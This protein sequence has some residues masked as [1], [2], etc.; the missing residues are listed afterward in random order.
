[1]G[2]W[3][4]KPS[5]K[6]SA[7]TSTP[8]AILIERDTIILVNV[9]VGRGA[10][11]ITIAKHYRGVD[12]HDKYYNKWFM[13]KVPN[14]EWKKD[15]KFKLKAHMQEVNAIQE[16]EDVRL[17]DTFYKMRDVRR[18]VTEGEIMNVIGKLQTV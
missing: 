17:H 16:Y 15:S 2:R 10:S 7:P 3:L 18:I 5:G 8:T 14:K 1:M 12:V 13:S 9:R 4:E 11:R 6:E